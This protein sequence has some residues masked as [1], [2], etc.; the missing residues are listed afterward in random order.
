MVSPRSF[1][2]GKICFKKEKWGK[3]AWF[4][5]DLKLFRGAERDLR[6]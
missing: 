5:L 1:I 4:H 6:C 3:R 2:S